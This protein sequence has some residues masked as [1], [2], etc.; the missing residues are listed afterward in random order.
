MAKTGRIEITD[1]G[2]QKAL[3]QAIKAGTQP[4]PMLEDIGELLI[5]STKRRFSSSTAPDGSK[6]KPNSRVTILNYLARYSGSYRKRDGRLTKQGSV[7]A[8][9]KKPLI[10]ETG[11]LSSQIFW[12]LDGSDSLL[13]GSPMKYAAAQHFGMPKGYASTDKRG[14]PIPWGEIPARPFL[15]I[16]EQDSFSILDIIEEHHLGP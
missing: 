4:K 10:G 14:R 5:Q 7:R 15:G 2:V 11:S 12:Q 16:S 13:V 3:D 8:A 9:A 6:W 1:Q